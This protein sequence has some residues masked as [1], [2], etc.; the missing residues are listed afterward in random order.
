M[1]GKMGLFAPTQVI[2]KAEDVMRQTIQMY[3]R[4]NVDFHDCA[5]KRRDSVDILR[6]SSEMGRRDPNHLTPGSFNSGA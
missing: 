1:A 4:P 3:E 5:Q 6:E 2:S